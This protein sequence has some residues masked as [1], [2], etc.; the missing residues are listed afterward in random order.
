MNALD[1]D[2]SSKRAEVCDITE[3]MTRL[4]SRATISID[5]IRAKLR[6]TNRTQQNL[7]AIDTEEIYST[8]SSCPVDLTADSTTLIGDVSYMRQKKSE[9]ITSSE[10]E[11][12]IKYWSDN[13]AIYSSNSQ[14]GSENQQDTAQHN[15]Q[16]MPASVERAKVGKK[17]SVHAVT[18]SVKANT[19]ATGVIYS[20]NSRTDLK[21]TA[22]DQEQETYCLC[23]NYAWGRMI[24]C[25]VCD[26]WFHFSCVGLH[27]GRKTW[28]CPRCLPRE[29][30]RRSNA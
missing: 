28:Q 22:P 19:G 15:A 6:Q 5:I 25:D 24:N 4:V 11:P 10:F 23:G 18:S 26:D 12:D 27:S 8:P 17:V 3:N 14:D 13:S 30:K 1:F 29:I 20:E 7:Q 21:R 2:S 9:P 16:K